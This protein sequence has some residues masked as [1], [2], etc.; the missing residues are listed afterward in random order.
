MSIKCLFYT[1]CFDRFGSGKFTAGLFFILQFA[2][3]VIMNT[4]SGILSM[5]AVGLNSWDFYE[6]YDHSPAINPKQGMQTK[7][8]LYFEDSKEVKIFFLKWVSQ[9]FSTGGF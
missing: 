1:V 9:R 3:A 7:S 8:F 5:I 6:V 4:V 2:L